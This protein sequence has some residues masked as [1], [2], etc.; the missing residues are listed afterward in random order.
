L[1]IGE[2]ST[3]DAVTG[4]AGYRDAVRR[5]SLALLFWVLACAS[6]GIFY[7]ISTKPEYIAFSRLVLQPRQIA[8][9]GPENLRYYHQIVL[10]DEQAETELEVLRSERLLRPVF[11][12][13]HL[14]AE[15]ELQAGQNGFWSALGRTLRSFAPTANAYNEETGAFNAFSDRV[16]SRRLGLSYVIEVSYRGRSAA[17]AAKIVNA[18]VTTYLRNRIALANENGSA[19]Y[20]KSRVGMI[21]A[22]L[23]AAD[24][25]VRSGSVPPNY[26][27][28][29][30]VRLLGPSIVPE[31][32]VYP[33]NWALLVLAT[34]FGLISG[35]LLIL[36][37]D[38]RAARRQFDFQLHP[39]V[40]PI[41]P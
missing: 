31:S 13:L 6:F 4:L 29:S 33:K 41:A 28:D 36:I 37:L 39:D 15:P 17:E 2:R 1:W 11:E 16:R 21:H 38:R 35:V 20:R 14:A 25:A 18:V 40:S 32:K 8:I 3:E 34:G 22:E 10:D 24:E 9:D 23:A 7:A 5:N 27:P 12:G 30:D 19:P 26:L